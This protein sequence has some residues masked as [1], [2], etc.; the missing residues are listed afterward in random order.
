M[1]ICF[2]LTDCKIDWLIKLQ[3]L[4]DFIKTIFSDFWLYYKRA[5]PN[6]CMVVYVLLYS[7]NVALA[8]LIYKYNV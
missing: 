1:D 6:I 8:E 3:V 5:G 7:F 4:N 2:P